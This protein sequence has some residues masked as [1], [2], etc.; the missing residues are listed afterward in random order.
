MIAPAPGGT[1]KLLARLV[2]VRAVGPGRWMASCPAH[3]D[4]HKSLSIAAG[5]DGR[6]LLHCFA[7]CRPENV[8]R[9]LGLEWSA[10]FPDNGRAPRPRRIAP[11]SE[12]ECAIHEV[13]KQDH[14]AAERRREWLPSWLV[15]DYAR[16]CSRA[17]A[18][19]HAVATRL[20]SEDPRS[21]ALLERAAQVEREGLLAEVA[22]DAYLLLKRADRMRQRGLLAE[23]DALVA[24]LDWLLE[25]GCLDGNAD[26]HRILA[27][28]EGRWP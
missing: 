15:G 9:A 18:E 26:I 13:L 27:R 11:Q 7:A 19:A 3:E 8:L 2:S 12:R 20:G 25:P 22:V 6:V 14:R 23:A 4:S 1:E 28:V 17:A 5:A 16:R 24:E 21:W 10:L